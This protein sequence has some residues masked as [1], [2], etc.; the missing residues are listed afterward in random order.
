[1]EKFLNVSICYN[2]YIQLMRLTCSSAFFSTW[3]CEFLVLKELQPSSVGLLGVTLQKG[4]VT[5]QKGSV[6]KVSNKLLA[7]NLELWN[8]GLQH[9]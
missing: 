7:W 8:D 5:L 3:F 2:F 6:P 1:M 4:G 9:N